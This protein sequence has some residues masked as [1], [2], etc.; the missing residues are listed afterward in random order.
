M[1]IENIGSVTLVN[2]I[3]RIETQEVLAGGE[4]SKSGEL[5]IPANI[6]GTILEGMLTATKDI[7]SK[8]KEQLEEFE[9]DNKKS[10]KSKN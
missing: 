5:L 7:E 1:L 4:V 9:K 6:I 8:F 2:G 3:V 10:D